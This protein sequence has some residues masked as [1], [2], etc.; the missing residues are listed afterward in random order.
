[1]RACDLMRRKGER[2]IVKP[3]LTEVPWPAAQR[4]LE[5]DPPMQVWREHAALPLRKLSRLTKI[6]E[7]LL[8]DLERYPELAEPAELEDIAKALL[9]PVD[10]LT[11]MPAD[12]RI[13]AAR[14]ARFGD[15]TVDLKRSRSGAI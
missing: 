7:R 11:I 4:I 10:F 12:P 15:G 6:G 3:M 5:G 8:M 9:I 2:P 1:M 13:A 14:D